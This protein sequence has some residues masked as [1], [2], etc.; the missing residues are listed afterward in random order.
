MNK[1]FMD[2]VIRLDDFLD[3]VLGMV[4]KVIAAAVL[5][6]ALAAA[7]IAPLCPYIS[8]NPLGFVAAGSLLLVLGALIGAAITALVT[9]GRMKR[10]IETRDRVI[11]AK[12]NEIAELE[13]SLRGS[14]SSEGLVDRLRLFPKS[15]RRA[16]RYICEQDDAITVDNR[17]RLLS[18][19]VALRDAGMATELETGCWTTTEEGMLAW[20][21]FANAYDL[22]HGSDPFIDFRGDTVGTPENQMKHLGK[23]ERQAVLL[24]H[25]HPRQRVS[26]SY[27]QTIFD[28]LPSWAYSF[29]WEDQILDLT[30]EGYTIAEGVGLTDEKR[31][32]QKLMLDDPFSKNEMDLI[33]AQIEIGM[34]KRGIAR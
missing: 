20:S 21:E 24:L 27:R 16:L 23:W 25:D 1:D 6:G 33:A 28:A 32:Y 30:E 3:S 17:S 5:I 7:C 4:K 9:R 18:E 31:E 14:V 2:D 34:V 15:R 8:E 22:I 13:D 12:D 19:L 29:D 26:E 11:A 10:Q